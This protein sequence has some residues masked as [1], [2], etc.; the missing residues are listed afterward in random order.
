VRTH[1]NVTGYPLQI[2]DFNN[3]TVGPGEV[4][5]LDDIGH[6]P[7]THGVITGLVPVED[8][9]E[10]G[11]QDESADTTAVTPVVEPKPKQTRASRT[12]AQ[13]K[14]QNQ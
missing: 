6:D 11:G 5:D 7:D 10:D 3:F 9:P 14:E 1:R 2:R 13:D 4:V 12:A 8:E